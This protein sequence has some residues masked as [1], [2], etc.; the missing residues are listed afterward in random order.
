M[1]K[2]FN[3]NSWIDYFILNKRN[4]KTIYW[5]EI[6]KLTRKEFTTIYDSIRIFQKGESSEAKHIFKSAK[7]FL[8]HQSDQSYMEALTLFINEEHRHA[9]E[10]KRFMSLQD[11]PCLRKHW[12]DTVFRQLRRFGGLEQS[13]SVLLTAEFIAAVYYKALKQSTQSVVLRQ[14]CEQILSDE[15]MHIRFQSEAIS[16]F[17]AGRSEVFNKTITAAKRILLEG[18]MIIVWSGHEKVLNK[19]GYDFFKFRKECLVEFSK[20]LHVIYSKLRGENPVPAKLTLQPVLL[21]EKSNN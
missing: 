6:Y 7:Q 18:T 4:L 15:Q 20:S 9:F 5:T 2:H 3:F 8:H 10:L 11:I 14:I 13:I 21:E 1:A 12:S 16:Q 19:G 17:Y